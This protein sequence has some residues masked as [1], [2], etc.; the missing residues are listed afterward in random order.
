MRLILLALAA[1]LCACAAPARKVNLGEPPGENE[2]VFVGRVL[3]DPPLP[4]E[5][6]DY[7]Q[8]NSRM[9]D[10]TLYMGPQP[11]GG[12]GDM[13]AFVEKNKPFAFAARKGPLY[14]RS[15]RA[16]ARGAVKSS[17]FGKSGAEAAQV[18][19][20]AAKPF[21]IDPGQARV[22]YIG[23]IICQHDESGESRG[24]S[25]RDDWSRD[26]KSFEKYPEVTPAVAQELTL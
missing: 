20:V 18:N 9:R 25:V 26:A 16:F 7:T 15:I 2:T 19:C 4:E 12:E 13:T 14:L 3:F 22:V 1:T 8:I 24:I 10:A 23:T 17:R 6:G 11:W 5:A 21:K